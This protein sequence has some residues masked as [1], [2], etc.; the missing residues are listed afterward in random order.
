MSSHGRLSKNPNMQRVTLRVPET[1]IEEIEA[2][3][4]AGQYPN[5]SEAIRAAIRDQFN[6]VGGDETDV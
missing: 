2:A 6:P 5:R 1:R 4:E 3:V